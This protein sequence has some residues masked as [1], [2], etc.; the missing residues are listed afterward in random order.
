MD[1]IFRWFFQVISQ[2]HPLK[3]SD[4][5]SRPVEDI[6]GLSSLVVVRKRVVVVVPTFAK[7]ADGNEDV[8]ARAY[9]SGRSFIYLLSITG[10]NNNY[11]IFL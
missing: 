10:C 4:E 3:Q 2:A 9:V 7:G 5:E 11:N 1:H 6:E 8:L